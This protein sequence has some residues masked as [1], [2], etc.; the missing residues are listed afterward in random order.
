M[1]EVAAACRILGVE[2]LRLKLLKIHQ[3]D[4]YHLN[5]FLNY[6]VKVNREQPSFVVF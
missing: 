4:V 5:C 1:Q 6:E 3:S 2:N